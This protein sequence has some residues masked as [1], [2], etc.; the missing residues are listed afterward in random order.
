MAISENQA[1][2]ID[3][4]EVVS[5][6]TG[7]IKDLKK[8]I[9]KQVFNNKATN[10]AKDAIG[11]FFDKFNPKHLIDDLF[12]ESPLLSMAKDISSDFKENL[13]EALRVRKE[14]KEKKKELS[15]RERE[16]KSG[17]AA[18][19]K[20][21]D[22]DESRPTISNKS[23][24]ETT[25]HA[26][27]ALV[28]RDNDVKD[29]FM[30]KEQEKQTAILESISSSQD[31]IVSLEKKKA[32]ADEKT[33]RR[34]QLLQQKAKEQKR[35]S[36]G[37]FVKKSRLETLME[38]FIKLFGLDLIV[39]NAGGL[40]KGFFKNS[41]LGTIFTTLGT[42]FSIKTLSSL[43]NPK[44]LFSSI[45]FGFKNIK[46]L[47]NLNN[48]KNI[49]KTAIS[50]VWG[51]I[52]G[53]GGLFGRIAMSILRISA[54]GFAIVA[55]VNGVMEAIK[56]WLDTEDLPLK[57]RLKKS[58]GAF[59]LGIGQVLY[60]ASEALL[61]EDTTKK[62]I[63]TYGKSVDKII[64]V[65]GGLF[66]SIGDWLSKIEIPIP[67]SNGKKW[68]PFKSLASNE[69]TSDKSKP[70]P[71]PETTKIPVQAVPI[72]TQDVIKEINNKKIIPVVVPQSPQASL[73]RSRALN[74]KSN[75]NTNLIRAPISKDVAPTTATVNTFATNITNGTAIG[76]IS[77]VRDGDSTINKFLK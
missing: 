71:I 15:Q 12:Y 44:K 28:L 14:I 16:L 63:R 51:A 19:V 35:D 7:E 18:V 62:W 76:F 58:T 40:I 9:H 1:N 61:G 37:K 34:T 56:M 46:S 49:F 69:S 77:N 53:F 55:G 2:I 43:L 27:S 23:K 70:V 10:A 47:F 52:K 59:F 50:G 41:I 67:F 24:E 72:K 74:L 26:R 25:I 8:D 29:L 68:T 75:E 38:R 21:L 17:Q 22:E 57:E 42:F 30:A 5:R 66:T 33:H 3:N 36:T 4:D 45:I 31:K 64:D 48:I 32:V 39:R 65:V 73:E 6:L 11:G 60:A 54:W 20:A 13:D